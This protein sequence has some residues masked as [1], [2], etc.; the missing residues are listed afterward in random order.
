MSGI[1]EP[2]LVFTPPAQASGD[3]DGLLAASEVAKLSLTADWVLLSACNTASGAEAGAEA[4]SGLGRASASEDPD[5]YEHSFAFCDVLVI[6]AGPAGLMAAMAAVRSGARVILAD[7]DSLPGGRLNAERL[8]IDGRPAAEWAAETVAALAALPNLRLLTRT[9][10]VGVY[11]GADYVALERVADHVAEPAPH[12][13]RQRLWRIMAKAAVLASGAIERP[14]VFGG[15]D[16]P[17]VMLAGAARTYL[18]R[19][20]V[21]PGRRVAL[22]CAHDEAWTAAADLRA[23]AAADHPDAD[24]MQKRYPN[25]Q[26]RDYDGNPVSITEADALIAYLQ[27]LGTQVN[28]KLYDNKA[29]IR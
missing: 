12:Q 24:A 9:A 21:A 10:V 14:I 26:A 6:G 20:A 7:E 11:D 15:N 4:A 5:G 17:G 2:G 19:F 18:N 23:Q 25:A 8:D 3:D 27:M 13:P 16:R 29:N 1:E 22:F 28:F